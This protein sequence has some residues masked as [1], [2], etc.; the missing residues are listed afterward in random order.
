ME[1]ELLWLENNPDE[2][3]PVEGIALT[4]FKILHHSLEKLVIRDIRISW[5]FVT[6]FIFFIWVFNFFKEA[7]N[8]SNVK[9]VYKSE[10]LLNNSLVCDLVFPILL[11]I[12]VNRFRFRE[13]RL[14]IWGKCQRCLE[15]FKLKRSQIKE[16][17]EVVEEF[18]DVKKSLKCWAI[19]KN[20]FRGRL[21]R[22]VFSSMK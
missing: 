14:S 4:F 6:L 16:V 11:F 12:F 15:F 8:R 17:L 13:Y 2:F 9:G 19:Y 22:E 18:P 10:T 3:R 21:L 1:W 7:V 5:L 20:L